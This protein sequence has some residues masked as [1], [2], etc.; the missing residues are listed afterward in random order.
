MSIKPIERA[1]AS[2]G[3]GTAMQRPVAGI[4]DVQLLSVLD[5]AADGIIIIDEH[6]VIHTYNKACERLFGYSAPEMIGRNVNAIMPPD[7]ARA[8]DG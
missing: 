3:S 2:D 7:V 4:S 1:D 5:T 6:G 8:H